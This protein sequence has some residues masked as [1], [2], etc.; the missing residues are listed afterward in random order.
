[1]VD[2]PF[3]SLRSNDV[4]FSCLGQTGVLQVI[5][6]PSFLGTMVT[7]PFLLSGHRDELEETVVDRSN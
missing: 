4:P 5:V 7:H 2:H 1:M 3:S 6:T